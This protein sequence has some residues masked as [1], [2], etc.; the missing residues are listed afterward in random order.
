MLNRK[1][2]QPLSMLLLIIVMIVS[3]GIVLYL[4]TALND[5]GSEEQIDQACTL[6]NRVSGQGG[7]LGNLQPEGTKFTGKTC[8]TQNTEIDPMEWSKCDKKYKSEYDGGSKAYGMKACAAQ[9]VSDLIVRC[10]DMGGAGS[11]DPGSWVCFNTKVISTGLSFESVSE[12]EDELQKSVERVLGCDSP[13]L[14]C[15]NV[16]DTVA[17]YLKFRVI[18]KATVEFYSA[19]LEESIAGCLVDSE[20]YTAESV[21]QDI[22]SV[23]D[24]LDVSTTLPAS[25]KARI[26]TVVSQTL[27]GKVEASGVCSNFDVAVSAD[28]YQIAP[29]LEKIQSIDLVEVPA[30]LSELP[31]YANVDLDRVLGI[32]E[33]VPDVD[34]ID[35]DLILSIM[36]ESEYKKDVGYCTEFPCTKDTLEFLNDFEVSAG[37]AFEVGFCDPPDELVIGILPDLVTGPKAC[38]DLANNQRIILAPTGEGVGRANTIPSYCKIPGMIPIDA[39]ED[40]CEAILVGAFGR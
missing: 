7:T 40:T 37:S 21:L 14:D 12:M 8:P 39:I 35:R 28:M 24:D 20:D 9:Q 3:V 25:D 2:L 31:A 18:S 22:I 4:L 30:A 6:S 32:G 29:H 33:T 19:R 10:W 1:G 17:E 36:K 38:G 23:V 11:L 16:P 34:N 26:D 5:G 27:S 15:K 13:A